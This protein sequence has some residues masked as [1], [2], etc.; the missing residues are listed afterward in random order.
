MKTSLV[1]CEILSSL[2]ILQ[3]YE[4]TNFI[5]LPGQIIIKI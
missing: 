5:R 1:F 4:S 2:N 3:D